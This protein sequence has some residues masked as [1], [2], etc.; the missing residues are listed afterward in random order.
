MRSKTAFSIFL[1]LLLPAVYFV[2][3]MSVRHNVFPWPQVFALKEH[4]AGSGTQPLAESRYVFDS[5]E[6]LVADETKTAVPCPKQT[7]RT[8]VLLVLGQSNAANHGGQRYRSEYGAQVVNFFGGKCFVAASPLLGSTDARGEYWTQLGNL[9]IAS[10]KFDNVVIAPLA[11]TGSEVARWARGGDINGLLV[12]TARQIE[13]GGYGVTDVLWV[14][15]EA[16]YVKGT[17]TDAY[18]ERF[19]SMVDTLRGQ[20]I[21][22]P[23]YVAIASKCLEPSNGGFKVNAP[24]NP[25]V[26]AQLALSKSGN[27][28]KQG[29]NTDSLL[30]E[31]DRYDDCH[32]DGTG[33]DK[34]S[35]A[36]ADL[37]LAATGST[38]VGAR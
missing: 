29:V 38:I 12:E 32:I 24:D 2:G 18:R 1:L 37:L 3:A 6:R 13:E 35:R 15:G 16:D 22:A 8:A 31:V 34:V 19:L 21:E 33:S 28:L 26:R 36:W 17:S 27:G 25:V 30:D 5:D 11:F 20:D 23:V 14:Q 9:L 7:D 4:L 10:G